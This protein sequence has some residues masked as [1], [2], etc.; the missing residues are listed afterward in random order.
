MK[1]MLNVN[2]VQSRFNSN[3]IFQLGYYELS[4]IWDVTTGRDVTIFCDFFE[5]CCDN[6]FLYEFKADG[7]PRKITVLSRHFFSP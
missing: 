6:K 4:T 3:R 7:E 2:N 1:S 5:P